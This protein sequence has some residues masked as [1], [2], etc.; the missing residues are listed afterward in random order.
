MPP[1]AAVVEVHD[2]VERVPIETDANG[3]VRVGHTRLTLESIVPAFDAGATP[4]EIVQQY[5]SVALGDV[6]LVVAFYLRP[7]R[8][9][10]PRRRDRAIH[11]RRY[12]T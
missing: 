10:P 3:V 8:T 11:G 7:N 5:P 1:Y 12:A 2:P 6:F 4:E 9:V